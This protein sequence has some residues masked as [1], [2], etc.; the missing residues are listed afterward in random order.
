MNREILR[1]AIPNIISNISIPLLSSVDTLLM[2][3]LSAAHLGAV[4]IGSMIFN[5]FYWNF[6]F[7]RMGT[8]GITAQALGRQD[9]PHIS[10]TLGRAFLI[11]MVIAVLLLVLQHPIGELS[12][13]LMN[14]LDDQRDMVA[15][16]FY[17][18]LYAA[19]ATLGLYALFGWFFGMQNAIYPL[20][21]TVFI[22]VVNIVCSVLFVYYLQWD[23]AG[24]AWGTVI[25]QYAGLLLALGLIAYRYK[26]Y[27]K[28]LQVKA[29]LHVE[30]MKRFLYI[31]R[32]IFLR[33]VCLTFAFAF[34]YSKSSEAGDMVLATNVILMQFLNWMSY[35]IDGF[36]YASESLTGKYFGAKNTSKFKKAVTYSFIWGGG[37]AVLYSLFYG[38]GGDFLLGLFTNQEEVRVF[39]RSYLFWM[40][41]TPIAGF[42]SYIWDGVFIG[43]TASKA[44]RNSMVLSLGIYL[45]V[46]YL[47]QDWETTNLLW[48]ALIM[49]LVA[50]GVIQS[51]M[52]YRQGL[53]LT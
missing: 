37:I 25:A 3:H 1:L 49:F 46:Y 50:R 18:R 52:Y 7:L 44:M 6:G 15:S 47:F 39:A 53:N 32:D 13:S 11:A 45:L 17:I 31:N 51:I 34:F 36:A 4:G 33:T 35:G 38:L 20:I 10:K 22:N 5:F 43:M 24:V 26:D 23:I 48:I 8:T 16:Y 28:G 12:F 19:P 21:L 27:L 30:E 9:N 41:I 29:L 2:G 42:W 40:V 14:V